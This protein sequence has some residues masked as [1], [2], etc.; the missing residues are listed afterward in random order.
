V[1]VKEHCR[2]KRPLA[3]RKPRKSDVAKQTKVLVTEQDLVMR[4]AAQ[5]LQE[6]PEFITFVQQ[7]LKGALLKGQDLD[8][9]YDDVVRL[10]DGQVDFSRDAA[11]RMCVTAVFRS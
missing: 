3:V 2:S 11:V 9:A 10:W 5:R 4:E 6:M 8:R 1:Y 7:Q